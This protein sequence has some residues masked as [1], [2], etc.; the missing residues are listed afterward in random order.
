MATYDLT[1]T[2][3]APEDLL[4]DDI[5]NCAYTG[6]EITIELPAG[7]FKL[8]A[9]GS[10]GTKAGRYASLL[11]G[12]GGYSYGTLSLDATT[13]LYL[14]AGG[15][16]T[17]STSSATKNT[18]G[19]NG[20]GY[21]Y[22]YAGP[23]GGAT[24]IATASGLLSTLSSSADSII[25]VAGGGGGA[26]SYSSSSS[27]TYQGKGGKGGGESGEAGYYGTSNTSSNALKYA[28]QGGTQTAGGA[29]GTN[30]SRAGAA[31][32]FGQGGNGGSA[33]SSYYGEGGGGGGYY[34][35][36]GASGYEAG[37]GGGSGYLS[38][39][40]T[41]SATSQGGND[42]TGYIIITVLEIYS[43][44]HK[45]TFYDG[46]TEIGSV[47]TK[48]EETI[49]LPT[50]PS[51]Y[52]YKF[53]G[54]YL[55]DGTTQIT[56][57]SYA[58]TKLTED[59]ACFAKY[60]KYKIQFYVD[61]ALLS[62]ISTTGKETITFPEATKEG[63]EFSLWQLAD[64][65][66][67]N[68][69][70]LDNNYLTSDLQAQAIFIKKYT[71]SF[72]CDGTI[73]KEY[74]SIGYEEISVPDTLPS[75]DGYTF[76]GWFLDSSY[77]TP[78]TTDYFKNIAIEKDYTIY[79][80]LTEDVPD[81][82]TYKSNVNFYVQGSLYHTIATKGKETLTLPDNPE[83]YGYIFNG[84][85]SDE[86]YSI[87][88]TSASLENRW[89]DKD[90]SV[91]AE[92]IEITK[93][94]INFII[95]GNTYHSYKSCGKEILTI[96]SNPTIPNYTFDGWYW[97]E[98]YTD[99]FDA[100]KY[101]DTYIT[102]DLNVYAK[103]TYTKKNIISFYSSTSSTSTYATI[104]TTGKETLELPT[105][106][107]AELGYEFDNWYLDKKFNS[108]FDLSYYETHWLTDNISVYAKFKAS[109]TGPYSL[110]ISKDGDGN[111]IPDVGTHSI[112]KGTTTTITI[113]PTTL[114]FRYLEID[115]EA[116][117]VT[118]T[119][120]ITPSSACAYFDFDT[121]ATDLLGRSTTSASGTPAISTDQIKFGAGS[122]YFS[123]TTAL[124]I[125]LP[126]SFDDEFTVEF[127]FYTSNSATSGVYPTLFSTNT[128]NTYGGVYCAV[129]DGAYGDSMICR[130]NA[131]GSSGNNGATGS[132]CDKSVWN[133]FCYCRSGNNNYYFLNGT[134][135][136]TVTQS[137]PITVNT[138][139]L[140]G[141]MRST[142]TSGMLSSDYYTGYIDDLLISNACKH[143][144]DFAIPTEAY[145]ATKTSTYSYDLENQSANVTATAHFGELQ[146]FTITSSASDGTISPSGETTI[147][148]GDSQTFTFS[149]TDSQTLK[150]LLVNGVSV[151]VTES[152][153]SYSYTLKNVH[154]DKI[155]KA[156]FSPLLYWKTN[157]KWFGIAKVFK[158]ANG[159][160]VEQESSSLS[161]LFSATENYIEGVNDES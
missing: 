136:A 122:I 33:S 75:K 37:G 129:D 154:S 40:L 108:V 42:S 45:I 74:E 60:R 115:G 63:Y 128:D 153:A 28:G 120:T 73:Y 118:E 88:F 121:D 9:Y 43:S 105:E 103:T 142:S 90:L 95:N 141:L 21:S 12:E 78:Y 106:P 107:D 35:G 34:G 66:T 99:V 1:K 100:N 27:S 89:I 157:G 10:A 47:E 68:Q 52:G 146:D 49:A 123:G 135:M 36:G 84:W 132:E 54:Y 127:W 2:I 46:T 7:K 83:V 114:P 133:H 86:A 23:G 148:E 41:D 11:G 134:L 16:G 50:A 17:S 145:N 22:Y 139:C 150:A 72:I 140:G 112:A 18:G 44:T 109:S 98:N 93:Y 117:E 31:G 138:V 55:A 137:T 69:E 131:A 13:R 51:K 152:G 97:D 56:E 14:N 80:K 151:E 155:V 62:T 30:S 71:V 161:S 64:G 5:L 149:A 3:P 156:I 26:S 101:I 6:S 39:R 8:E 104:T 143:T 48:G 53:L 76:E 70:Y 111:I 81:E 110:T 79:G 160:W 32:S 20:G 92:L 119:E 91:Y 130:A 116:V 85:F 124:L 125:T 96:P 24:H 65:T 77:Q 113:T 87:P 61:G 102:E 4:A 147:K 38:S 144:S 29:A 158:K 58:T 15:Q 59:V 126:D 19:Y 82:P 94:N 25:I 57:T 67:L 159:T